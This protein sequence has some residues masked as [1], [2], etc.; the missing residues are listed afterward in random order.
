MFSLNLTGNKTLLVTRNLQLEGV[1]VARKRSRDRGSSTAN[2]IVLHVR[3]SFDQRLRSK[4]TQ[5]FPPQSQFCRFDS[6]PRGT[7]ELKRRIGESFWRTEIRR[8]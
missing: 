1:F 5:T 6:L 4:T 3:K 7:G 2:L 8:D